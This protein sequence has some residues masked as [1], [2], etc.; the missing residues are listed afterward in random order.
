MY[1]HLAGTR[2]AYRLFFPDAQHADRCL[3]CGECES[4]CPQHIPIREW[5]AKVDPLLGETARTLT[6]SRNPSIRV[7]SGRKTCFLTSGGDRAAPRP[8]PRFSF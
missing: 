6:S 8:R 3:A 4:K 2:R 7:S 5:L 1:G